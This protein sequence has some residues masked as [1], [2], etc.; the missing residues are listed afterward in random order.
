VRVAVRK[1]RV[2]REIGIEVAVD[3]VKGA[4]AQGGVRQ[5]AKYAAAGLSRAR[6]LFTVDDRHAVSARHP[7]DTR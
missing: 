4:E 1:L 3:H 2:S 7:L 5:G 6:L